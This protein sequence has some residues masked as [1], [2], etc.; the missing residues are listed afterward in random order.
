MKIGLQIPRFTWPGDP[1]QTGARL[2]EIARAADESGFDSLW[3]MDHFFQIEMVGAV[4]EPMFEGYTTLGYM[5]AATSKVRLGTLVTGGTYRDPGYLIKTVTS[6]DVL[7][8]GRAYLG[9]G[10]GWFEREALGLGL[11][12]PPLKE[13]FERLE[14]TLQIAQHMWSGS[15]A[16]YEGKHYRLAEPLTSPMP[17]SKPYPPIMIGGGGEQKT[18][19][20][21]AK[22]GDACNLFGMLPAEELT[23]KF[24]ILKRHCEE[25]GRDENE[26]ERTVIMSANISM[27]PSQP[28]DPAAMIA[29]CKA[30]AALGVQ[31]IIFTRVPNVYEADPVRLIGT[32]VIPEVASL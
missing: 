28:M 24:D 31:H 22:Y 21:V 4:E 2:L 20:L 25:V 9:I 19:R 8:N 16:P 17:I 11:F 29:Y 1:G 26:I 18:L 27:D 5:A 10:A 32:Q 6:L 13:R 3:V 30:M 12:F 15:T 23:R 14:E 7:T